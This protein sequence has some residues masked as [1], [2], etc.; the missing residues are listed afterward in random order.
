MGPERGPGFRTL[1][2]HS[3]RHR[4]G[5][6]AL[7]IALE[8]GNHGLCL[9]LR[10]HAPPLAAACLPAAPA[11]CDA[12]SQA[13]ATIPLSFDHYPEYAE[14]RMLLDRLTAED[15]RPAQLYSVGRDYRRRSTPSCPTCTSQVR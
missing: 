4:R 15:P 6:S 2:R 1:P 5:S 12:R 7:K 9:L 3:G 8:T 14:I 10:G 11:P 13:A